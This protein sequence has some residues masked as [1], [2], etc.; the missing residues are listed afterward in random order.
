MICGL[1]IDALVDAEP[2]TVAFLKSSGEWKCVKVHSRDHVGSFALDPLL[3]NRGSF[4]AVYSKLEMHAVQVGIVGVGILGKV[5]RTIPSRIGKSSLSFTIGPNFA[6]CLVDCFTQLTFL[7]DATACFAT[8]R[9][10]CSG[11]I[12]ICILDPLHAC[13]FD[14]LVGVLAIRRD[15]ADLGVKVLAWSVGQRVMRHVDLSPLE[16]Y[17]ETLHCENQF[18]NAGPLTHQFVVAIVG[19]AG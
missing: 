17:A 14:G 11:E 5:V 2:S 8:G 12:A 19:P 13:W 1:L 6:T 9:V 10:Q 3:M 4:A 16:E 18:R 7:N 15:V